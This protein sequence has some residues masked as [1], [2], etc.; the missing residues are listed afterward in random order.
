MR[1]T[2]QQFEVGELAVVRETG[3]EYRISQVFWNGFTWMCRFE[4]HPLEM[5]CGQEYLKKVNNV[6]DG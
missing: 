1:K 6:V 5:C 4:N 3:Q 2:P